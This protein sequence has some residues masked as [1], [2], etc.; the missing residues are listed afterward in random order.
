[1]P[2][3]F[4]SANIV[5]VVH[6]FLMQCFQ[7][8]PNL[9]VSAKKL[10]KHPWILNAKRVDAVIAEKPTKYDEAVKSVQQWNEAL[11]SPDHDSL[12]RGSRPTS[13][14]PAP[15]RKEKSLQLKTPGAGKIGLT[16]PKTR[17]NADAFRSP[18]LD[19]DDNWD[20]DFASSINPG[21]LQLPHLKPHDNFGGLL[22]A[23]KLKSIATFDSL[24]EEP[25]EDERDWTMRSPVQ[26]SQF[27]PLETV[28]PFTPQ[29][30]KPEVNKPNPPNSG[31]QRQPS[32]PKTQIRRDNGSKPAAPP[33]RLRLNSSTRP[34]IM[35]REDTVEDYSDLLDEDA[36]D[37]AFQRKLQALKVINHPDYCYEHRI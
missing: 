21:A 20:D 19:T 35:F 8:D 27:D 15:L 34:S 10:L 12:R 24:I 22:S 17:T 2:A 31:S 16:L 9:R 7:K 4:T 6:D 28:K 14:S 30:V 13:L 3:C 29:K 33:T 18:E 5:Q 36:D 26:L 11:K 25:M 32:Q 37:D 23:E 1:L